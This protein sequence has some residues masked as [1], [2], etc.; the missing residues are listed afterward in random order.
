MYREASSQHANLQISDARLR[1]RARGAA[2][3]IIPRLMDEQFRI[4][5]E[6]LHP[7]FE[8][9]LAMTPVSI[10]AVPISAPQRGVYLITEA[11]V[12]L[13]V[14]RSNSIRERLANHCRPSSPPGSVA[15]AF[16]LA[17]EA[18]GR[19]AAAYAGEGTRAWLM[20]QP[21]FAQMFIESKARIRA[22]DVRYVE[23]TDSTR[24]ALLEMYVAVAL[25]TPYNDF[26][27]H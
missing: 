7:S 17:R 4:H 2:A 22:M 9:L 1:P 11:G 19:Q 18:A 25:A 12:D 21:A 6:A 27:T 5:V 14:G 13:Y 24:Q 15:F 3:G 8:R 16:K 23:E 20:D 10:C 26:D